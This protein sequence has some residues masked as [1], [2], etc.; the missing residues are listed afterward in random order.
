MINHDFYKKKFDCKVWCGVFV[1][2]PNLKIFPLEMEI[3]G[4]KGK[5]EN[6]SSSPSFSKNKIVKVCMCFT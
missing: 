5:E 1:K 4:V 6:V 2:H 3:F